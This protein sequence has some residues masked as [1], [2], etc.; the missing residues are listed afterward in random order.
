MV[1]LGIGLYGIDASHSHKLNLKPVTSLKTTVAQIKKL[2]SGDTVGYNRKGIIS[3]DSII[4][5]LR[6]GYADGLR[7]C[8]SNGNG[9]VFING[10][11]APVIGSIAMDMTM[12]DVTNIDDLNEGDEAEIFGAHISVEDVAKSCGS[13]AYEILP[14]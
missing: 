10:K 4:A 8:L 13:I 14:V 6:I 5:T 12:V 11:M 2:H 7:R 1:R 3:S 9:T